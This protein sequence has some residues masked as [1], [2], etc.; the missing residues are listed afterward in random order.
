MIEEEHNMI[1]L[2][3][4]LIIIAACLEILIGILGKLHKKHV[5][6]VEEVSNFMNLK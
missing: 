3:M 5:V 2:G 1:V 6:F 4:L